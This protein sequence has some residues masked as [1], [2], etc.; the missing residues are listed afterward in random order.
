MIW[1]FFTLSLKSAYSFTTRPET[2]APTCTVVRADSVPAAVT[3][4]EIEPFVT[5][6]VV[7]VISG[8]LGS[9][10]FLIHSNA[11][12]AAINA[13]TITRGIQRASFGFMVH[14]V[15]RRESL[16]GQSCPGRAWKRESHRHRARGRCGARVR[17]P[18]RRRRSCACG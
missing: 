12:A 2:C 16:T 18:T 6:T 14:L 11:V 3:C 8:A 1:S 7:N 5:L 15:R 13:I 10:G 17:A 4:A 9:H